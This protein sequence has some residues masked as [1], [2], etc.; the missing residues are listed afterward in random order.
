MPE[1]KGDR[2]TD[3]QKWVALSFGAVVLVIAAIAAVA[4]AQGGG[5]ENSSTA[6]GAGSSSA[7]D[8]PKGPEVD[9]CPTREQ[10]QAHLEQYGFDYK[11]TVGCYLSRGEPTRAPSAPSDGDPAD[12]PA[13]QACEHQKQLLESAKPLPDSDNN[14]AT[15]A[16]KLPDGREVIVHVMTDDPKQFEDQTINDQAKEPC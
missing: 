6:Q 1:D 15:M 11:P 2:V 3:R 13:A 10:T 12:L 8:V 4:I 7:V 14:P 5:N 16:G 9:F